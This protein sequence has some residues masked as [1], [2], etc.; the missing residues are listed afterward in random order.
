MFLSALRYDRIRNIYEGDGMICS[1]HT[2]GIN[3]IQGN[4]VTVECYISNGLPGFDIVGLPDAA[5]KEARDRVRAAAKNSGMRFPTS[6]IT[7]NLAPASLKKTG[8]HYDLPILLAIMSACGG[9]RRPGSNCAFLGEVSLDG[10]IRPISGVL[11]MAIAAK[12][13]GFDTLYVPA[14]NA[15]EA[16]LSRGPAIIP[17]RNVRELAAALNGEITLQEEPIWVPERS[18]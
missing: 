2:L 4:H 14:D 13:A 5:V 3:G 10:Q 17:V 7:V 18:D 9:I 11:P 1:I 12:R 8:T 15:A 16:T 6:R